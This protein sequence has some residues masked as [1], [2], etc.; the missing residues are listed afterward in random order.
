MTM[1]VNL[2]E[3]YNWL[4]DENWEVDTWKYTQLM[5][6][7][8]GDGAKYKRMLNQ[9]KSSTALQ[10][11]IDLKW[12][13]ATFGALSD[14]ELWFITNAADWLA[15]DVWPANFAAWVKDKMNTMLKHYW[16]NRNDIQK[17]KAS[18]DYSLDNLNTGWDEESWWD[19]YWGVGSE[20][21]YTGGRWAFS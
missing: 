12:Q 21:I 3:I 19:Y 9:V 14:Q 10:K 13:W 16:L 6:W 7:I 18:W 20:W 17:M 8:Y 15:L 4:T 5:S 1:L 11:L 2:D